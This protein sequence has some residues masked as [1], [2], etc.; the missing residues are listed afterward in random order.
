MTEALRHEKIWA[1]RE[2]E[3]GGLWFGTRTGGLYRWRFAKL[4]HFTTAQ[5]LASNSIYELVEDKTGNFWIQPG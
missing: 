1:I 5:G 2:D 3:D 4:T